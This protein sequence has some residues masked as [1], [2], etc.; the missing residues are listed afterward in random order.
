MRSRLAWSLCAANLVLPALALLF[1]P[2]QDFSAKLR[3]E[4]DLDRI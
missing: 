1:N 3:D 4:S 2:L